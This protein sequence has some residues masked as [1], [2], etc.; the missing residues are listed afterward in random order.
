MNL[1]FSHLPA[2]TD[3]VACGM[4]RLMAQI[5]DIVCSAV[6]TVLPPG[7]FMTTIPR[8]VA[9]GVSTLSRPEP[10]RPMT[11]SLSA[12]AMSSS[13]TFV[14]ERTMRPSASLISLNSS[15]FGILDFTTT[16]K[17]ACSRSS[18][19]C[20]E[21]LSLTRIFMRTCLPCLLGHQ[22]FLCFRHAAAELDRMAEPFQ[23]HLRCR[24]RRNDIEPVRVAHVGQPENFAL[25]VILPTGCGDA[26]L[27][28]QILIHSLA[29]DPIGRR[30]RRERVAGRFLGEEREACSLHPFAHGPGQLPL[31]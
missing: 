31:A 13:V 27:H 7:V 17:P 23:H 1:F 2:L 12:A 29:V 14:P 6:V 26:V 18:T 21:R 9:A 22:K 30:H 11:F 3:V 4:R 20:F 19:P 15:S 25:E 28:P 10:A 16:A 24:D 8:R 5:I